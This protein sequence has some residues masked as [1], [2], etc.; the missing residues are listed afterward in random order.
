MCFINAK[1]NNINM[2]YHPCVNYLSKFTCTHFL[3]PRKRRHIAPWV[4]PG[5]D[6]N[7]VRQ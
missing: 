2:F 7:K 4:Y 3:P 1:I 6:N 5:G